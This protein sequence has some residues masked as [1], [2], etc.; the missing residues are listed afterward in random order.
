MIMTMRQGKQNQHGKIEYMGCIRNIDPLVCPLSALA[1]YFFHRWGRQ[2]AQRFPS[3]RQ[4]EDYYGHYT[5]PGSI[6]VPERSLSYHT[7]YDWNKR[8][9]QGVEIHSKET[10]HSPRKQ[11]A[12]HGE[13]GGVPEAQIRRAG[14]WNT[15]A[16][17]GV[18]LSY[19]PRAFIRGD[20]GLST[21]REGL[22]PPPG[23][24]DPRGGPLYADMARNRR[25]APAHGGL[26]PRP[27]RQRGLTAGSR[28]FRVST[29]PPYA[30]GG[31]PTGF[32]DPTPAVPAPS[33]MDGPAIQQRGIQE[34][35]GAGGGLPGRRGHARRADDAEV[36]AGPRRRG[37]TETRSRD[38]RDQNLGQKL[39]F[40]DRT[41]DLRQAR[42]DGEV[43]R[44]VA[45]AFRGS[46]GRARMGPAGTTGVLRRVYRVYTTVYGRVRVEPTKNYPITNIVLKV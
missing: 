36:L 16:L 24:G 2:H 5:F 40:R 42:Q 46:V 4:P 12:R 20:C 7:Q 43:G 9:F 3:F 22:L 25:L 27:D 41:I 28:R 15:D 17:T 8:M 1:F 44:G 19:L 34:V 38:F 6:R 14:R 35:C 21:G 39:G 18:Y 37:K 33:P 23:A 11:S 45:Y 31:P 29:P 13:L 10:T 26:S 32:R 30:P